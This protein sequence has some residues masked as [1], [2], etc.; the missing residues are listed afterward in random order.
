MKRLILYIT[1]VLLI[2]GC[3]GSSDSG[4]QVGQPHATKYAGIY[5]GTI[6]LQGSGPGGTATETVQYRYV[7][8]LDGEVTGFAQGLN[9]QGGSCD[10]LPPLYLTD[11]VLYFSLEGY[12]CTLPGI[13]ACSVSG[14]SRMTFSATAAS[15]S[16]T[17]NYFC[18]TGVATI[19]FSGVLNKVG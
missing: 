4:T 6:N 11:N 10:S 1:T 7:V 9:S 8:G 14:E 5:E 16:G 18:P 12:S 13:G 3:S 15:E 19:R 2:A 17:Y